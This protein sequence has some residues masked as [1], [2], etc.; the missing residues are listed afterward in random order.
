MTSYHLLL[1]QCSLY[2]YLSD[3]VNRCVDLGTQH[4]CPFHNPYHL[5]LPQCSLIQQMVPD[6]LVSLEQGNVKAPVRTGSRNQKLSVLE[7]MCPKN[8]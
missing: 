1:P 4:L 3:A 5:L 8:I 6:D 2:T 7:S